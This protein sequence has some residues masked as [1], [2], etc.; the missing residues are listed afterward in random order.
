MSKLISIIVNC[1]NGEKF[2]KKTLESIIN[3]EYENWEL[4]FWDNQSS[5][6]S[7]KIFYSFNDARFKYFYADE[8]TTLYKARNLASKYASGEFIAFLDCDDWWKKNFLNARK[9]FFLSSNYDF[10]YSNCMHYY[11]KTNKL[12]IFTNKKLMSG[13]I[14]DFL[15]K[16]YLVKISCFI[17]RRSIFEKEKKFNEFYNTIG[18]FE[19]VM[20]ISEK[21]LGLA[22]QEPLATIRFHNNNFLDHN[23]KMFYQEYLDWFKNINFNNKNYSKNKFLYFKELIRLKILSLAPRSLIDKFKKK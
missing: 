6:N 15:S 18:D 3:Q 11:Q 20:R 1:Y 21:Y 4:I 14:F 5:D 12:E 17:I 23:R 9:N 7:K 22:F 13:Q 2:L 19:Y 16:N 8:H 10:S